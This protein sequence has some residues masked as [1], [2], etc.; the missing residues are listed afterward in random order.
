M[1]EAEHHQQELENLQRAEWEMCKAIQDYANLAG[2]KDCAKVLNG[3]TDKL[4]RMD[5]QAQIARN[6]MESLR[7]G[8]HVSRLDAQEIVAEQQRGLGDV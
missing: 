7:I 5:V 8:T 1:N 6:T 2:I 4:I 3:I